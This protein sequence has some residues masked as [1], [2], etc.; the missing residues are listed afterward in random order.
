MPDGGMIAGHRLTGRARVGELGT[1]YEAVSPGGATVGLLRFEPGLVADPGARERLVGAV[2]ADRRLAQAGVA[3]LLPVAD[4]VTARGEVWL[5]AAAPGMPSVSDLLGRTGGA[6]PDAGSAATVLV[7]T[8]QTLLS[9][10]AAGMAHG[11]LHPGTVLLA[12][13]GTALLAERGLAAALGGQPPAVERDVAAWSSLA[14]G[15]SAGWAAAQPAAAELFDHVSRVAATHGLAAARDALL[16]HRDRLPA[17]FGTKDRLVE[18]IHWWAAAQV[19]TYAPPPSPATAPPGLNDGEAVTLLKVPGDRSAQAT[20]V[21]AQAGQPPQQAQSGD[22]MMRFGPGVPADTTA[23]QIW[24]AGR[25]QQATLSAQERLASVRGPRRRN[26]GRRAAVSAA[27]LALILTGAVL[28]WLLIPRGGLTP[29][30][31]TKVDVR[32]PKTLTCDK[33]ARIIAVIT[34]NGE[35]GSVRYQWRQS[36]GRVNKEQVQTVASGQTSTRV[37]LLWNVSGPGNR[38]FTATL[39]VLS[40]V[41]DGKRV[42]GKATF[43]YRC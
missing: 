20:P 33:T 1:W 36:D 31:V 7:E 22:V 6:G 29:L 43:S 32:G 2:L 39:R 5:I 30:A 27:V 26:Q 14:L 10:H 3:G 11:S 40:P 4:L 12:P 34:T 41:P 37:P 24:R 8:A 35:A 38:R 15:L 9:L 13:D 17:G 25:D 23:A 28:A 19:P 21:T 16:T 42:E 18:T